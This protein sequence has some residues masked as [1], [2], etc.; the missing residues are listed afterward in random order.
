MFTLSVKVLWALQTQE[1]IV[2][3]L[4]DKISSYNIFNFLL[5]GVIFAVF[6]SKTTSFTLMQEDVLSGAF[7]YYFLG[8]VISR[9][10]SLVVEP[11]LK[12]TKLINFAEYKDFVVASEIKSAVAFFNKDFSSSS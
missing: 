7:V 10:G 6:V 8:A 5:P 3:D 2:K 12:A 9:I 4:L 1:R 11:V